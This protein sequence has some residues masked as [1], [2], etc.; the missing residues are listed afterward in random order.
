MSKTE[1]GIKERK[2][3]TVLVYCTD[4]KEIYGNLRLFCAEKGISYNT[5]S[6]KKFPFNVNGIK[7]EK[8][9]ISYGNTLNGRKRQERL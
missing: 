5:Y 3:K 6:R 1:Q 4:P 7:L 9:K 8:I 2:N